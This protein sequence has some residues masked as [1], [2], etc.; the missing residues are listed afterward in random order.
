MIKSDFRFKNIDEVFEF[1][2]SREKYGSKPGIKRIRRLMNGLDFKE[3]RIF[4]VHIAGTNGKGSVGAYIESI[5]NRSR[6]ITLRFASPA[7]F[8]RKDIWKRSG[9]NINDLYLLNVASDVYMA[10]RALDKVNIH[11]TRFEVETAI[12]LYASTYFYNEY[13]ILETGMGGLNDATNVITRPQ[14]CVFTHIARDHMQFLGESLTEIATEK[15]GI[16]KPACK[17]FSAEQDPE[18]KAVLDEK[19]LYGTVNYV[20]NS[21]IKLIS[22]KPGELV[23]EYKGLQYE[24]QLSGLYQMK[25]AALAIDIAHAMRFPEELIYEGIKSAKWEG[26]FEV[27]SKE[28]YF[29]IDGAHNVDAIEQLAETIKSCFTNEPINFII[30]VLKDKEHEKMME[31]IAPLANKIYTITPPNARGMD[32]SELAEEIKKWNTNVTYCESIE[33]AVNL[34]MDEGRKTGI[35][36]VAFGS[37]SYLGELKSCHDNYLEKQ[38]IL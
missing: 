18:V 5:F 31:I 16:I 8:D 29:I 21:A 15:A 38:E 30:G 34:A 4:S 36:T 2:E 22:H 11:P 3:Q 35:A 32:G 7:V 19:M 9:T 12:A 26:R 37:L 1:L 27:L 24:T 14:I 23:F 17:A 28:P 10:C 33:N 20:D 6:I 25:N 13:I